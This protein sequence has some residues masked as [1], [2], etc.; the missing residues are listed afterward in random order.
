VPTP[1]MPNLAPIVVQ[2]P[3]GPASL[4]PG[5]PPKYNNLCWALRQNL[6]RQDQFDPME[7]QKLYLKCSELGYRGGCNTPVDVLNWQ[8]RATQNNTLPHISVS[9][10][11]IAAIQPAP[12]LSG[13][14]CADI[15][16]M[17]GMNGLTGYAPPWSDALVSDFQTDA[18]VPDTGVG[19]WISDHPWLSLAIAV[20]G[21]VALSQRG[22]R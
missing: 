12:E 10:A 11:D 14:T 1:T 15:N 4:A 8:M 17:A 9:D 6:V 5:K 7:Y 20:G 19:K 22:K 3:V 21:A 2:T 13:R 18:S 16:I